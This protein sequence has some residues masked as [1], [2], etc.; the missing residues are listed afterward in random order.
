MLLNQKE[1]CKKHFYYGHHTSIYG[2]QIYTRA[3]N[4]RRP[5]KTILGSMKAKRTSKIHT[6]NRQLTLEEMDMRRLSISSSTEKMAYGPS[7]C[8]DK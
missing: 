4:V 7:L 3:L 8:A 1:I 5:S 2:H 6:A